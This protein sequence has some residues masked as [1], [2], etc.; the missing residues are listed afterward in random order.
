MAIAV[1]APRVTMLDDIRFWMQVVGDSRR[2]LLVPPELESRAIEMVKARG[3]AHIVTVKTS[4]Y[5]PEGKAYI[6]DEQAI[7]AELH[8][9][10]CV[11][12]GPAN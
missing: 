4:Q 2:T 7:D 6:V 5:L 3:L 9:T 11:R 10:R 12:F 8:R 1:T